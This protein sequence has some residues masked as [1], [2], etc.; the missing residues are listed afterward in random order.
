MK[1]STSLAS[2]SPMIV[3]NYGLWVNSQDPR[4]GRAAGG[5][6]QPVGLPRRNS[7]LEMSIQC[8][9]KTTA[10]ILMVATSLEGSPQG[11]TTAQLMQ[12]CCQSKGRIRE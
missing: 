12:L 10:Y 4:Y 8:H 11:A 6:S 2:S 9:T 7:V 3:L 5:T 1:G